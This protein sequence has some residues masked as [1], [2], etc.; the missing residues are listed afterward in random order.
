MAD[1]YDYTEV[2]EW[3]NNWLAQNGTISESDPEKLSKFMR[4]FGEQV[5]DNS[6]YYNHSGA[7]LILY[8]G[9]IS[10]VRAW[11]VVE[12]YCNS[13]TGFYFISNTY[14]GKMLNNDKVADAILK[15][16]G[17]DKNLM[18]RVC[19]W[20]VN[21]VRYS[22]FGGELAFDDRVSFNLASKAE[23]DV[24]FWGPNAVTGK[25]FSETE[26]RALLTNPNVTRLLLTSSFF[27]F[28]AALELFSAS[29]V[30]NI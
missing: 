9:D 10:D 4:E 20:E 5:I 11:R 6:G 28:P 30:S 17:K 27:L 24:M 22:T 25:V 13:N 15:I 8:S 29:G 19:G 12:G 1:G 2:I 7:N 23:G 26:I 14:A 3:L 16:C 21:G 18:Y